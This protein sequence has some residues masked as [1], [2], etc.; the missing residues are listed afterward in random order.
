MV[1]SIFYVADTHTGIV[2]GYG[3]TEGEAKEDLKR[4]MRARGYRA[5]GVGSVSEVRE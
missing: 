2:Y 1:A 4:R 3:E 5:V